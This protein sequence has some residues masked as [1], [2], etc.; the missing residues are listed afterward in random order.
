MRKLKSKNAAYKRKFNR[1]FPSKFLLYR[2]KKNAALKGIEFNLTE[3]DVAVPEFCPVMGIPLKCGTDLR[4]NNSPS[5]DRFDNS[6]G[7]VK[8]NIQV[9]SWRA[10][11]LKSNGTL[12]EFKQLVNWMEN[13]G[14]KL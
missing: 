8:D 10:N 5:I 4:T 11:H 13:N 3:E 14:S 7:Y 2:A 9:I 6:K 12:E 1:D